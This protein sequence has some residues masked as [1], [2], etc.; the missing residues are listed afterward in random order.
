MARTITAHEVADAVYAAIPRLACVLP[1]DV[2]AGLKAA[3]EAEG[4]PR[5]RIVLDQLVENARIAERDQVPLCQDTGTVWASLEIGP[6]VLVA[7]DVLAGVDDAVARA[8]DEALLRKSVVGNAIFDRTNSGD[9]TPAF[10]DIHPVSEPGVA[11]LHIMLKGGGSD[12]ASRVVMLV[13][14]AGRA[15][16]V[17]ALV[18]CVREK[19]ANAC[20]P[21]V[22]GIGIGATFDKVAGLA[23]RALMRPID[24]DAPDEETRALEGELLAAVN[25]TGIGAGALGGS[26]TALAVRVETAPCHI[27][28][29]PLA[30]N[31]GCSAM[32]RCTVDL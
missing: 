18:D 9:N 16:I 10:T 5:G 2:L 15:G 4:D 27:A 22:I 12:N 21:L 28:A 13:P 11:R 23:K 6:D 29:L 1:P 26:H 20:P 14:G 19:A 24:A 32:R 17:D 3:R 31:M 25:A 8:Y 7:G 30:I